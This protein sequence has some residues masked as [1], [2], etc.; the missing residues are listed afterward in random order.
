MP[1]VN[2]S[3]RCVAP[4]IAKNGEMN[5]FGGDTCELCE[6]ARMSE[7]FFEDDECWIAECESCG[8]PMVVWREHNPDPS[9]E[10][11]ERLIEKLTDVVA[12]FFDFELRID[13]NMRS[14]PDHYHAHARPKGGFYGHGLRRKN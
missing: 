7:W 6:A 1:S 8:V 9:I 2:L 10:I 11:R 12:Q 5:I 13:D 3:Q 14:I 4:S